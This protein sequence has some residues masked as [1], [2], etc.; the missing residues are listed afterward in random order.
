VAG[1]RVATSLLRQ[2]NCASASAHLPCPFCTRFLQRVWSTEPPLELDTCRACGV[3]WFDPQEIEALPEGVIESTDALRSRAIEA[4]A[5]HKLEIE[6]AREDATGEPDNEWKAIPALF[7]F[8]V[9]KHTSEFQSHPWVTWT[10]AGLIALISLFAFGRLEQTVWR[11][12]L[13]PDEAFRLGGLTWLTSFFLH[14]DWWHL[15]GNLYFLLIFGDNVEDYLRHGKYLLLLLG[16][17]LLAN[18][19][20]VILSPASNVPCIGASGGISGII[21]FY[22]LQFPKVRLSFLI[23][24]WRGFYLSRWGFG[25]MSIPAWGAL[26]LWL[27]LQTFTLSQELSGTS[28]VA[29]SAHFGGAIAG[30][31]AWLWWRSREKQP[32]CAGP[33]RVA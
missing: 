33:G 7:G 17:D 19:L 21:V 26:I 4:M 24:G 11:F 30:L 23:G 2:I 9:E 22:A 16:A 20:H 10:L 8:P 18:L 15:M 25:W 5:L 31:M 12:G 29:A 14:G 32:S 1:D 27:L 3:V 13:I 6:R 28:N